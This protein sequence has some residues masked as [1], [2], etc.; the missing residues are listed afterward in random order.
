MAKAIENQSP[1][2]TREWS[3]TVPEPIEPGVYRATVKSIELRMAEDDAEERPWLAWTFTLEDG[4][5]VGGGSSFSISPG[6]KPYAWIAAI[7]GRAAMGGGTVIHPLDLEGAPCQVHIDL[8]ED[9]LSSKVQ[10]VL[11]PAKVLS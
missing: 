11:P 5:E 10:A 6:S 2:G 4:R 8:K 3:L 9:G 7:L 1:G